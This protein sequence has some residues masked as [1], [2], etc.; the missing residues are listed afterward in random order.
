VDRWTGPVVQLVALGRTRAVKG[1]LAALFPFLDLSAPNRLPSG[2][3]AVGR[4]IPGLGDLM[5]GRRAAGGSPGVTALPVAIERVPGN[6]ARISLW[7]VPPA[8]VAVPGVQVRGEPPAEAVPNGVLGHA[9]DG[10]AVFVQQRDSQPDQGARARQRLHGQIARACLGVG[11]GARTDARR[12]SEIALG[13]VG[14]PADTPKRTTQ[15]EAV[16]HTQIIRATTSQ[17]GHL[18]WSVDSRLTGV[19]L[20]N[21]VLCLPG[22]AEHNVRTGL[23]LGISVLC[24]QRK[25]EHRIAS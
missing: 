19:G 25:A 22:E 11:Q 12:R 8:F 4:G 18:R 13:E 23:S 3:R 1:S 20:S 2:R 7:T 24:L 15:I 9:L 5:V 16:S 17:Q 21:S 10:I 6:G 14:D